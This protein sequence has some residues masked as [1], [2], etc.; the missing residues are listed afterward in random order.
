MTGFGS[1]AVA[2]LVD[3]DNIYGDGVN[4]AAQIEALEHDRPTWGHL[5]GVTLISHRE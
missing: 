5:T 4:V 3:G 1:E 2:L